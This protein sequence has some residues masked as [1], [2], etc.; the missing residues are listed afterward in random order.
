MH[1]NTL[2]WPSDQWGRG[3]NRQCHTLLGEG[4]LGVAN[5]I[6]ADLLLLPRLK[7]TPPQIQATYVQGYPSVH[8]F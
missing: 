6:S 1:L 2:F 5:K 7:D 8:Y 4:D 3:G